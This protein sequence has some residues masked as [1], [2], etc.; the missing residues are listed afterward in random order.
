LHRSQPRCLGV[1]STASASSLTADLDVSGV[2]AR[3]AEVYEHPDPPTERSLMLTHRRRR[4]AVVA[5]L[6][7]S[8]TAVGVVLASSADSA[9]KTKKLHGKMENVRNVHTPGIP[10]PFGPEDAACQSASGVCSRFTAK[11]DIKGDG[12]VFIDTFPNNDSPSFSKAHTV[13]TTKKGQLRCHE[14]ALFDLQ[15][16]DHAFVDE[17]IIDGGTGIY[18]GATGYIQEVGTFDF[19]ANVGQIEYFGK[20]TYADKKSVGELDD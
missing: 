18:E 7:L 4:L 3:I 16:E 1:E 19:A 8:L 14:A 12:L 20:I 9:P 2:P 15:G 13:I 11:G 6:L 10:L 5:G 17:C